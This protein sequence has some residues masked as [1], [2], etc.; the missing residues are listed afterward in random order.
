MRS[1]IIFP[2]ISFREFPRRSSITPAI[3]LGSRG[4]RRECQTLTVARAAR[5]IKSQTTGLARGERLENKMKKRNEENEERGRACHCARGGGGARSIS[6]RLIHFGGRI[7]G[8]YRGV[9]DCA[10]VSVCVLGDG[11]RA[12]YFLSERDDIIVGREITRKN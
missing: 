11:A 5:A 3:A 1:P 9:R 2:I 7:S 6:G 12:V 4:C 8:G 10:C